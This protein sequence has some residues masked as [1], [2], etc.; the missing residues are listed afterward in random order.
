MTA[1]KIYRL[2]AR[3][4][5]LSH[6]EIWL[7]EEILTLTLSPSPFLIRRRDQ[8][9]LSEMP[10]I[11]HTSLGQEG[12]L[13]LAHRNH[14][15]CSSP[16]LAYSCV[17]LCVDNSGMPARGGGSYFSGFPGYLNCTVKFA[18]SLGGLSEHPQARMRPCLPHSRWIQRKF[19]LPVTWVDGQVGYLYWL[20]KCWGKI[21]FT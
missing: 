14:A 6:A 13:C 9:I 15:I 20:A 3:S 8:R 10:Q 19:N 4:I 18:W 17:S 7:W 2:I 5:S 12:I 1:F 11:F 16:H 21:Y